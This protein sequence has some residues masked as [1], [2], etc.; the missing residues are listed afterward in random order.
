MQRFPLETAERRAERLA[1][2]WRIVRPDGP[3][4]FPLVVMLHGCGKADGPQ[5]A[6]AA[7]AAA[8]GVASLIVDS[9]APRGIGR[10]EAASL[11]CTGMRLWG[12]ERAGD[13]LAALHWARRQDWARGDRLGLAGWSHGGWTAMDALALGGEVAGHARLEGL[14][15]DP[16]A[17]VAGAFLVYPWCGAGAQTARR[18]WRRPVP[19]YFLLAERDLVSGVRM[20]LAAAARVA[21]GGSAVETETCAG[22]THAFDEV[23]TANPAYVYDPILA[24]RAHAAFADWTQRRLAAPGA[25]AF[26]PPRA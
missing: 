13:A 17:G 12:R 18:G 2:H 10:I 22:A 15:G 3:G 26:D 6:F 7:A 25:L 4:P 8:R 23:D 11:V 16:L 19:A 24:A 9:F 14:D 20:P 21:A 5:G 1:A